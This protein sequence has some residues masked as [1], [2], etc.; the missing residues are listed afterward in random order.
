MTPEQLRLECRLSIAQLAEMAGIGEATYIRIEQGKTVRLQTVTL[1][2]IHAAL[3]QRMPALGYRE[4]I[5]IMTDKRD[6]VKYGKR[7]GWRAA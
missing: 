7:R 5:K 1:E 4:F 6:E 3:I 2:K